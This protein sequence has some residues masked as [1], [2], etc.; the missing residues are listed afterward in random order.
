MSLGKVW[1]AR[2]FRLLETP[3]L[4]QDAQN[5]AKISVE[6]PVYEFNDESGQVAFAGEC[7]FIR[8]MKIE[9]LQ[10]NL[11]N[12]RLTMQRKNT[13]DYSGRDA[14]KWSS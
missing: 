10:Y 4:A 5:H 14:L 11:L 8:N 3:F 12:L 13:P 6:R 9:T 2:P 1:G 7:M